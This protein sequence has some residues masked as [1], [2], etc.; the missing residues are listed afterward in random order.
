MKI[1]QQ[2]N[3]QQNKRDLNDNI[4]NYVSSN[5]SLKNRIFWWNLNYSNWVYYQKMDG[6]CVKKNVTQN[7]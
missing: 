7:S 4:S 2:K 6:E 1:F 5:R 3:M